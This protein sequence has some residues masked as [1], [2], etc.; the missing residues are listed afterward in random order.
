MKDDPSTE[1]ACMI[2]SVTKSYGKLVAV[3]NVTLS[4]TRGE[5]FALVGPNGAGKTTL[6][7]LMLGILKAD[8]GRITVLGAHIPKQRKKILKDVGYL[9]QDRALYDLLTVTENLWFFGKI[10]GLESK[11]LK[12]RIHELVEQMD[13]HDHQKKL[14]MHCSGGLQQRVALA[15]AVIHEPRFLVLDEPTVGLDPVLREDFWEY[16][17]KLRKEKGVTVLLTTHYLQEAEVADRVCLML[18]GKVLNINTPE[19]L[20]KQ[21]DASSLEEAFLKAIKRGH[22]KDTR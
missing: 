19:Q 10:K 16:F 1:M 20:K 6:I 15:A 3:D 21:H 12:K 9:P 22:E 14:I 17:R 2:E 13:L 18:N 11:H 8:S 7:K 5:I 4:I